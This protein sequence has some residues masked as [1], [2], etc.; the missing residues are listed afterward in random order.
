MKNH[1]EKYKKIF[2][3]S[4]DGIRVV[5]LHGKILDVNPAYCNMTGYS[6]EEV[7]SLK[8][9]DFD[10]IETPEE[11]KNHIRLIK[12]KG[13]DCFE[14]KHRCKDGTTLDLEVSSSI[15][16]E[17]KT[18]IVVIL[19][20]I[21]ERKQARESLRKEHYF[22]KKV[23]KTAQVIIMTL[24]LEGKI[25]DFNPYME[26]ISGYTLKEVVGKDWIQTFILESDKERIAKVFKEAAR[27]ISIEGN[28]N[29]IVTKDGSLRSIEWHGK[30]LKD[31]D[32]NILGILSTGQDVTEREKAEEEMK[33]LMSF[34]SENPNPV[35]RINKDGKVL[36]SNKSGELL[37]SKW[38]CG[39]GQPV[40]E[41]W[42]D[43]IS[44]SLELNKNLEEEEEEDRVFLITVSPVKE[45]GYVNFYGYDITD[46]NR[47][48]QELEQNLKD[49]QQFKEATIDRE[50]MMVKLK[51][52][53][54]SLSQ[55]LGREVLYDLSF[56]E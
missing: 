11:I 23:I 2:D 19:K 34:P 48:R 43:I 30:T 27:G 38:E 4:L 56:L 45:S 32:G 28:I 53:V 17:E 46:R 8:I 26:K 9:P 7:L 40:P 14:T 44:K 35:M 50:K 22:L 31:S 54:N 5:D 13:S 20:N 52:Q 42:Q 6:R 47:S 24:D 1:D 3:N 37:L 10:V 41:R 33:N 12:E 16:N 25:L 21:T 51:K 15:L 55:E 29:S 39:V 18:Q 36:Y 49:L